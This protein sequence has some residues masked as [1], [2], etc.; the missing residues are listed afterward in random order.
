MFIFI[1]KKL[2]MVSF[3]VFSRTESLYTEIQQEEK[4]AMGIS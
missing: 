4:G 1:K 3:V 2:I